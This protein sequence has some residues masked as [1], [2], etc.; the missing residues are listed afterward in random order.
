MT[1]DD[2]N[3]AR[4]LINA[5]FAENKKLREIHDVIKSPTDLARELAR[6]L[7]DEQ[8]FITALLNDDDSAALLEIILTEHDKPTN[9]KNG[10]GSMSVQVL[11]RIETHSP[12]L[13]NRLANTTNAY[14]YGYVTAQTIDD[15]TGLVLLLGTKRD[16]LMAVATADDQDAYDYD[17]LDTENLDNMP[18]GMKELLDALQTATKRKAKL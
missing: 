11:A 4:E 1:N 10:A 6:Q 17:E 9:D 15:E 12:A 18:N 16:K 14:A 3:T 2:E 5:A 13:I 8:N 7:R